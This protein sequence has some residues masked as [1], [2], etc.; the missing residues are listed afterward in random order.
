M[1]GITK[2]KSSDDSTSKAVLDKVAQKDQQ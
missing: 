1:S 2:F